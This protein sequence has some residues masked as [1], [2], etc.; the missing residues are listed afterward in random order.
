[1]AFPTLTTAPTQNTD[2]A[3]N[4]PKYA[5]VYKSYGPSWTFSP[6]NTGGAGYDQGY[7]DG[8]SDG[9]GTGYSDGLADGQHY[10]GPVAPGQ[11][12]PR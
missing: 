11:L 1:M 4:R 12:W 9:Y 7:S 6:E 3:G 5:V 10:P 2:G 8:N